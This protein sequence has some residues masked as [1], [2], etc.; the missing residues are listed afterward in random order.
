MYD[1]VMTV[2]ALDGAA[3]ILERA[4]KD[5]RIQAEAMRKDGDL[6]RAGEAASTIA[7]AMAQCRLDLFVIRPLRAVGVKSGPAY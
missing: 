1:T 3:D 5:V 7:Q 2:G 4:A 6:T